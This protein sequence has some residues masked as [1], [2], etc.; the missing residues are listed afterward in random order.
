[1]ASAP[2]RAE[3]RSAVPLRLTVH[4]SPYSGVP[5]PLT[6]HRYTLNYEV[7]REFIASDG[8]D[9]V[10]VPTTFEPNKLGAYTL[11]VCPLPP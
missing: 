9:F 11:K 1:M 6:V 3:S 2:V 4:R 8:G 5:P 10:I 7:A